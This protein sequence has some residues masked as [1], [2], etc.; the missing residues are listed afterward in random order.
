VATR[1]LRL[2]AADATAMTRIMTDA[3]NTRWE[4]DALDASPDDGAVFARLAGPAVALD[5]LAKEI[6]ARWPG[7]T[8]P[9]ADAEKFWRGIGEMA[10]AHA[11]GTL[12]KVALTPHQVPEFVAGV[13]A[14]AGAR[15]WVSAGGNTGFISLPAGCPVPPFAWP[16]LTMRGPAPLWPGVRT[17]FKVFRAVKAA[18]DPV[19]RF[20]L[21]ED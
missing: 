13:R 14:S 15:T 8:L 9:D 20:P 18:L 1:T 10:W 21:L 16:A 6:F 12:V 2:P 17:N 7:E 11:D 19:N 4:L 5:P 3:A